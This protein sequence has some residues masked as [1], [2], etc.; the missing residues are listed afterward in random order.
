M[1]KRFPLYL[2][3]TVVFIGIVSWMGIGYYSSGS[4]VQDLRAELIALHG[5]PYTRKVE[6][7]IETMEF[8]VKPNTFF[9]TNYSLRHFFGWDYQYKCEVMYTVSNDNGVISV[10]KIDYIG[11]DPM[12]A[13]NIEVR[14]YIDRGTVKDQSSIS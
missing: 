2:A 12:G 11:I 10:R 3:I 5:E 9:P 14:A 1:K 4:A 6:A 13:D 7:G 8:S